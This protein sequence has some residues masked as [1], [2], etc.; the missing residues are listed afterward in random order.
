MARA[1]R[2][3]SDQIAQMI[4]RADIVEVARALGL[5]VDARQ[6]EPRR[7]I[8]PFHN[9]K[10]PSLN[11][12]RSGR[13][14]GDRGH[15]HCFVCGAH[16]D[17]VTLVREYESLP[18]PN[19]VVR[20]AEILGEPLNAAGRQGLHRKTGSTEL[21]EVIKQ[22]SPREPLFADYGARRGFDPR[23]LHEAGAAVVSLHP[24]LESAR[25]DR[26][27]EEAL[28][29]AGIA[30]RR[31][32]SHE[33]PELWVGGPRG[34]FAGSRLV[35]QINTDR[36]EVAGFA[37]RTLG[38]D[39]PKYL[40]SYGFPR[41]D[42]LYR[43]DVVL[44]K[45]AADHRARTVDPVDIYVVEGLFDALR[46][47][48]LGFHAVAVL[49]SQI[50]LG[51]V[52]VLRSI[53]SAAAK[54]HREL[55]IHLFFDRDDAGR[56]GAYDATIAALKLLGEAEPFSLDVLWPRE[57][58]SEK[59]DPD[60]ALLGLD[61]E[62]ARHFLSEASV[63]PLG[64]L[65]AYW[66]ASN[67]HETEWGSIQRLKLASVARRIALA[68]ADTPWERVLAPMDI[69]EDHGGEGLAQLAALVGL[70]ARSDGS[71][72]RDLAVLRLFREPSDKVSDLLTALTLGR[73]SSSRREY[74]L[75]D[76]S[77]DRLAVAA[78]TLFHLHSAR[79]GLGDGPSAPLLARDLPK[80]GGRYRLKSGPVAEDA[81]I[82]QYVLLELLRDRPE[83]PDF[84][85][86]IPAVRYAADRP[87]RNALYC[88]G[89]GRD[90][91]AVS[92]AYQIDMAIVNGEAPPRREGLFRP[93]FE[94]WRL[95]IDFIDSKVKC[96][97]HDELQIL[98]L[99]ITGFYDNIR[100][101]V[102]EDALV[103]PLAAALSVLSVADGD[104]QSFAPLLLNERLK[105]PEDRAEGATDFLLRHT[106]GLSHFDP[107]S[108]AEVLNDARKGIP[109]GPDLSA[110]LANISLFDLDAMMVR[111]VSRINEGLP[112]STTCSAAYARYVDD[113]V[114]VCRDIETASQL[115]RKIEAH[116]AKL[117]L[118]LNRKN[119]TP[120]PM[121]RGQA[122]AWITDNR[123]GFGFSGPLADLPTTDSMDPLAEAGEI[124]R[125]TAL[126]LLFDPDLDNPNN[127]TRSLEHITLALRASDL[128]FNDRA[129]AYRYLWRFAAKEAKT[130]Q[131]ELLAEAFLELFHFVNPSLLTPM[132]L[133]SRRDAGLAC[134]EGLD[135]AL[136][137]NVPPGVLSA[138]ICDD[139]AGR[140]TRIA[141]AVLDDVF[142]PLATALMGDFGAGELLDRYDVRTQ[143]GVMA[144]LA[145]QSAEAKWEG[146]EVCLARLRPHIG[147]SRAGV[148][149]RPLYSGLRW[150]LHRFDRT[151]AGDRPPLIVTREDA[152]RV[153]FVRLH[154][155]IVQLQRL[156][157][158]GGD[159]ELTPLPA[160][161]LDDPNELVRTTRL[162]L[163][164]WG[165]SLEDTAPDSGHGQVELD[166]AS[167]LVNLTYM[168]FPEIAAR[169]PR[170]VNM[171]A[172]TKGATALP[173][174]PGLR[175]DGI[176]L[177][178]TD[179]RL[180][181]ASP[182]ESGAEPVGVLWKPV[183]GTLV[184]GVT[185]KVAGL[186][187][188]CGPVHGLNRSWTPSSIAETYRT[189]FPIWSVLHG[190]SEAQ[191]PIPTVF[192]FFA[193]VTDDGALQ[194]CKMVC[195]AAPRA[196]VD[197]HAFVRMGD[198]LEARSIFADGADFWRFGWSIRDLCGRLEVLPDEE[199]GLDAH[200][201]ASL[202]RDS[203]RREA[204][205]ARVL[206][207]LS[208]A[209]RWGPGEAKPGVGIPTRIERGLSLLENFGRSASA[210]VDAAYLVAAVA[211]GM[212]MSER[213]NA[214][215]S[216]GTA[217]F[218]AALLV[219][220]ARRTMRA[221]PEAAV[222]WIGVE[223]EPIPYRRSATAWF[224]A[225]AKLRT[226]IG[227]LPEVATAPLK[228]LVLGAELLGVTADLRSLAFELAGGLD[229]SA[230]EGLA[231]ANLDQDWLSDR[232]GLDLIL[233]EGF[234][235]TE[236]DTSIDCQARILTTIFCQII[237]GR[238][239]GLNALR[240]RI[241]PAGW[242]VLLAILLQIVVVDSGRE[243]P[244]PSLW[245]MNPA[246]LDLAKT[247]L[248]DLLTFLSTPSLA[249]GDSDAWPWDAFLEL[250]GQR[251]AGLAVLLRKVTDA[252]EIV[253]VTEHAW[254]NPRTF[255]PN[256]GREV[257]RLVDGSS[258]GLSD[259]QIDIA[260]IKG[261]KGTAT[262][263][264]DI[265]GQLRYA[266]SVARSG[267]RVLGLHLV[268]S[269]LAL[270]AFGKPEAPAAGSAEPLVS[271]ASS[272]AA[273][274][275]GREAASGF[276][277]Q[278][279]VPN[280]EPLE[281]DVAQEEPPKA[282]QEAAKATDLESVLAIQRASWRIRAAG[283]GLAMQRIAL[284]QWDV[285]DTYNPPGFR[286][287]KSE[288]LLDESG[289]PVSAKDIAG[290]GV[291]LSTTEHR[292]RAIL[293]AV[294]TACSDFG[295]DGLVLPEYC[296]RPETI[297][298]LSR[299]LKQAAAPITVWCGT[300]RVPGGTQL[301]YDFGGSGV[302]PFLSSDLEVS[303]PGRSRYD[304][305][306]ALLTCLRLAKESGSGLL[307]SSKVRRKRYPS[308]AAGELIRPPIDDPWR[309][310]LAE[311]ADPFDVGAYSIELI[312]S[313][314]FPHASSA[315]FIGVIEENEVLAK[316]YGIGSTAETPF[317]YLTHDIYEFAKWT[318]YQNFKSIKG[319]TENYLQR[320]QKLQ[321]TLIILPAMTTRSADYHI[322][323]QNQ[324][325]AA[326]LVTVF[327]NA[328]E[329]HYGCG[330][331][332]FIG[333]DGWRK[334]EPPTSPYGRV[335]PGIFQLGGQHT[336]PLGKEEAAMVIADMDL[337]RTTDQKPR[338]HYQ[339]RALNLV[340]HLPLIFW[341][342]QGEG[343]DEGDYPNK[344]RRTRKRRG[345]DGA[346]MDTFG[347]AASVIHEALGQEEAWRSV[348]GPLHPGRVVP[349]HYDDG[350]VAV[351]RALAVLERFADDATW[352]S[353]RHTAFLE[354]RYEH[355]SPR[356]LPA[357][358]DWIFV[359]DR[360][361]APT[362]DGH[363]TE[364]DQENPLTSDQPYLTVARTSS[365]PKRKPS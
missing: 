244:R 136:R 192:S 355:P 357:V 295:V 47:E 183:Q 200:A 123:A 3:Q 124:D 223:I 50:T 18:F 140:M 304:Y 66:L 158:H 95:F 138:D 251:P 117:G 70:Y 100:R 204:I 273:R 287:G 343:H 198:A 332:C 167:T 282:S 347:V 23:W 320:G 181:L 21:A 306:S 307:V 207:R 184:T 309:P 112:D 20:L 51:Q 173:S 226:Q 68:L 2:G 345:G 146:G 230:I 233:V 305:H 341:T 148:D 276:A 228:A 188:G 79:L 63:S 274:D 338:P 166:A 270:A 245:P 330:E 88:T 235:S 119:A 216:L 353:K 317:K 298:W 239:V 340:A 176:L 75:D 147:A 302:Q 303:P 237:L 193:L 272:R 335:A 4:E 162:I 219:R 177:W 240:D 86:K 82:Q 120:P 139:I 96:F 125:K 285:T 37:A 197:G 252:A 339:G 97:H 98:R 91:E 324:Y 159:E 203:H 322:F 6:R 135:R 199:G 250:E 76:A 279:A 331:S 128:R 196:T 114:L 92:F 101:D 28:V 291:F 232:V 49:G 87:P 144:R 13:A 160:S 31:D 151:V 288:G 211:E 77:W 227:T 156:A 17:V 266:Y 360:W 214:M 80:G 238:G 281:A 109:Q 7:A 127:V 42:I 236:T 247:V 69:S 94:C 206:P 326:G 286:E 26:A 104:I 115:R 11:L 201:T 267:D 315:N 48:S 89:S 202:E 225:A 133:E 248:A 24:L 74:P 36:G 64:F 25:N 262:E 314:M 84:T 57:E 350:I 172:G 296:L 321:R 220:A 1:S 132:N 333:L 190:V 275:S 299:Q 300:F 346:G 325:L 143:I 301:D 231:E 30:R 308:A 217:G 257:V 187:A 46:L 32:I 52:A 208:G 318:S 195:W 145:A 253:V 111:E 170:L 102:V 209:D 293:K 185:L 34:F 103:K 62:A 354:E 328:F 310:L 362:A 221:L 10:D 122:R 149:R 116:L 269:Q 323:G 283:K 43:A 118:T 312:C 150:S 260:Y 38:D 182:S 356:P 54:D 15:Y 155:A 178:C 294:L 218:P 110:Y 364:E 169:R 35:F 361:V 329:A 271:E 229:R 81:L 41:R 277:L 67:P 258:I 264:V 171:I 130:S 263:S 5:Q 90:V 210:G 246:R 72:H 222:H 334:T 161:D 174:P 344:H 107:K 297:N 292:R 351:D 205:V 61:G 85:Q 56:R 278:H 191:I 163:G 14:G 234:E 186:P 33:A 336:G 313:E 241:T 45:L 152:A 99:D 342:E 142:T 16:G 53:A 154:G 71:R 261:E 348:G 121:T 44:A 189:F 65:A 213:V 126:G 22:A 358:I 27:V 290:G 249:S 255:E 113:I 243:P 256:A 254:F 316:R 165:P 9:D 19:A 12:Y 8:C 280:A 311:V 265:G 327:C 55:C 137:S 106:F 194:D 284:V 175:S 157:R 78:S 105:S 359:D 365:A 58:H 40:Y 141:K 224:A 83:C 363:A 108:G 179:G 131:A 352:L 242:T 153:A 180:L 259:W 73:S 215:G 60:S 164:L 168:R 319:D 212:F 134:L 59:I 39:K 337:L 268:S 29:G 93:Y 349:T 129:N 289:K